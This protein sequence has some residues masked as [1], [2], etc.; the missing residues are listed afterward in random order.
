MLLMMVISQYFMV[1]A[2]T[3][4]CLLE[5]VSAGVYLCFIWNVGVFLENCYVA[6]LV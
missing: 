4:R 1:S 2:N 5:N 3:C 6:V